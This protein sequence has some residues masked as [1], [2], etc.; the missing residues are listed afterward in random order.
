M[1]AASLHARPSRPLRRPSSALRETQDLGGTASGELIGDWLSRGRFGRPL[2]ATLGVA[3]QVSVQDG[4]IVFSW[5]HKERKHLLPGQKPK[6]AP[7]ERP[8]GS[9]MALVEGQDSVGASFSRKNH[10]RGVG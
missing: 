1:I 10:N 9:E 3:G 4:F 2:E 8:N 7:P 5:D 6:C